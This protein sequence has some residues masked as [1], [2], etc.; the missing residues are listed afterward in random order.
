MGHFSLIHQHRWARTIP[1]AT[2]DIIA[3][4]DT[5]SKKTSMN[6]GWKTE[7]C[8]S[9]TSIVP[10]NT[11]LDL[12]KMKGNLRYNEV[13]PQRPQSCLKKMKGNLR[14]DEVVP[15][16]PQSYLKKMKGNLRY[17]EVVPQR[18][19]SYLKK[20]KGKL[21]YNEVPHS[22]LNRTSLYLNYDWGIVEV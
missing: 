13:V 8:R 2:E 20:M 4:H 21:R 22:Y 16:R 10:H 12:K 7:E 19:Q 5:S 11:S 17:N 6:N 1:A 18:P 14:Y 9:K 15:Q 3:P